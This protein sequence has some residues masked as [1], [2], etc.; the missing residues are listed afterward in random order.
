MCEEDEQTDDVVEVGD[1]YSIG[2]LLAAV[3]QDVA[4][5]RVHQHEL[6]HLAHGEGG[7]PP[8]VLGVQ[9]DEVVGVHDSV[10]EAVQHNG[11]VH[12]AVVAH[13]DVQPVELHRENKQ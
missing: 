4:S 12:I 6:H 7:L 5:L 9:R 3:V 13:V 2:E 11:E 10:D 1:D 8:D